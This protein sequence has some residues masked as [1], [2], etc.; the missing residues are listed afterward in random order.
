MCVDFGTQTVPLLRS[1]AAW[2]HTHTSLTIIDDTQLTPQT[3]N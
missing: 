1:M 2:Q 3:Y